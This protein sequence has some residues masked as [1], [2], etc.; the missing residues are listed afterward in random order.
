[1]YRTLRIASVGPVFKKCGKNA[2]SGTTEGP[3]NGPPTTDSD[4]F[5]ASATSG[6]GSDG[7]RESGPGDGLIITCS[8]C[9]A[10]LHPIEPS[11]SHISRFM[12]CGSCQQ[13]YTFIDK[14]VLKSF[15]KLDANASNPPPSPKQIHSYLDRYVVGQDHAKKVLS[16]QVYSHYNRIHHNRLNCEGDLTGSATLEQGAYSNSNPAVTDAIVRPISPAFTSFPFHSGKPVGRR[17]DASGPSVTELFHLLSD[18]GSRPGSTNNIRP[19]DTGD[20]T[21]QAPETIA[22]SRRIYES[23]KSEPVRLEKSNIILLG[24]TGSGK[25]WKT[26]LAQTL[27]QCLDVPFA[28]CDCTTLTQAGYVGEDIESVIAKLLQ[29]ANFNVERAQQGIVFL[30]EVD[31]ISSRAGLLHSI[32][33]VGGEGVQQGMLKMLEGSL[34]SVP[35]GKGARKIRGESVLVDTTNILFIA[36]GAFTGLDKLVARRKSKQRIGFGDVEEE[37]TLTPTFSADSIG[38]GA[39][40]VVE[41]GDEEMLETDRLLAQVEARDL[42]EFGIIPEFVGRFPIITAFHALSE[43][44]LTR[45][46][47]EPRNAL[48]LQYKLLFQIDKCTLTVTEDALRAIARQAMMMKTGARGLRAIMEKVLLQPRYDVPGSG[49]SEVIIDEDVILG[50]TEPTYVYADTQGSCGVRGEEGAGDD[51]AEEAT[52]EATSAT[53]A[54]STSASVSCCLSDSAQYHTLSPAL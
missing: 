11:T 18:A 50:R 51:D 13:L 36:S 20:P 48:L 17:I 24:P 14:T 27:A 52:A 12:K 9:G 2:N 47:T 15:V 21:H 8:K 7:G 37:Q 25:S 23:H 22:G 28:I 16:V 33:D 46:L 34:V 54:G 42:I 38:A 32:R 19:A 1:M 49:I 31:K 5:S 3:L 39:G 41:D 40:T 35:D 43:H 44:M 26:L 45:I 4:T 10:P 30:D 29:N 6:I 53:T